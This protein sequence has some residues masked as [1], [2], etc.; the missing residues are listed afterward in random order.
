MTGKR[1][2][3]MGPPGGG[4]GTQAKL[5]EDA[6]GIV[7]LSTGDMLRAAVAAGTELGKQAKTIMDA[8]QLVS[9]E[10]MV[11]MISERLDARDCA[12]GFILDGFP[13]TVAQAESLDAMLQDKGIVLDSVIEIRVPDQNLVDRITGRFTC[14][15]CGEGYHDTFKLPKVADTCDACGSTDFT[16]RDDDNAETVKSRLDAYHGQTAPLLPFYESKGLL[17][18]VD[19]DQD[20]AAVTTEIKRVLDS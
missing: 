2:V 6:Y 1:L 7:Q 8:G 12:N 9:D 16:R 13:R 14:S 19:G 4:K 11:G 20:M 15:K 5:L 3:L 18:V 17:A 10:I